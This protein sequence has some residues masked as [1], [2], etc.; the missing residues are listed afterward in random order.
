MQQYYIDRE[1]RVESFSPHVHVLWHARFSLESFEC[2]NNH[3]S[4]RKRLKEENYPVA[5]VTFFREV[6]KVTS[7]M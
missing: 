4:F 5:K 3:P 1:T 6:A 7:D 2:S